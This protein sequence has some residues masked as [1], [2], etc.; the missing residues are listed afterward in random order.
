[1]CDNATH[2]ISIRRLD[3]MT[4]SAAVVVGMLFAFDSAVFRN[5]TDVAA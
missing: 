4:G 5:I 3:F 1:L 2:I